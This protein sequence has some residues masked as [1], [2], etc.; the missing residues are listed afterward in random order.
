[1]V[2]AVQE[3][4]VGRGGFHRCWGALATRVIINANYWEYGSVSVSICADLGQRVF[5][6]V[7]PQK[8]PQKSEIL[9][10]RKT[11]NHKTA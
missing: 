10:L 1:H 11:S 5:L 9:D 4:E 7:R 2:A 8:E 3:G 6:Q